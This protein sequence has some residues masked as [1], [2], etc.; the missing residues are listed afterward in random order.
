M[1]EG[2]KS[3][4]QYLSSHIKPPPCD[5]RGGGFRRKE[6]VMSVLTLSF[7]IL[8]ESLARNGQ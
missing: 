5:P 4:N 7:S 3:I 1:S 6:G 2:G 8:F